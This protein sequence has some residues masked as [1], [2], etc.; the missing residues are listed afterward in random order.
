L[1]PDIAFIQPDSENF[2]WDLFLLA[3]PSR[4]MIESYLPEAE[5]AIYRLKDKIIGG[6]IINYRS[7]E[8]VEL[9]NIAI[10]DAYQKQGYGSQLLVY[11]IQRLKS[12]LVKELQLGT[13]TFGHQLTFYHR[14]GFRVHRLEKNY[15]L[16]KYEEKIIENGIRHRD[17][18]WLVLEL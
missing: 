4:S 14:H 1:K 11:L 8:K 13:G 2:P 17:R 16:E 12:K 15:F 10:Y 9:M 7:E 3:D 5:I 18:L 6:Y